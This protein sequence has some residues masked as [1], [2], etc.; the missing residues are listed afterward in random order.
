MTA[1]LLD[2]EGGDN[3]KTSTTCSRVP[4]A[5]HPHRSSIECELD[6]DSRL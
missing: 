3:S 4:G 6:M 2:D 5:V 1:G